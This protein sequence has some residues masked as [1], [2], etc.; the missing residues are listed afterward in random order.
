MSVYVCVC[1]LTWVHTHVCVGQRWLSGVS[2]CLLSHLRWSSFSTPFTRLPGLPRTLPPLSP[3][4]HRSTGILDVP[5]PTWRGSWSLKLC[6]HTENCSLSATTF[7]GG[8]CNLLQVLPPLWH[9]LPLWHHHHCD[10]ITIVTSFHYE[11]SMKA[12]QKLMSHSWTLRTIN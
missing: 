12:D 10:I 11:A 8:K 4:P 5:C 6:T 7:P 9:Y 1:V 2:P 3:G